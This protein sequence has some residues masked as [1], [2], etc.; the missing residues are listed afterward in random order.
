MTIAELAER[1]KKAEGP[2]REL[3][4]ALAQALV[5]DV[6]VLRRNDD[7]TANEPHTYWEYTGSVDAALGLV[8]RVLPDW[9]PSTQRSRSGFHDCYLHFDDETGW[10]RQSHGQAPTLPLA[11]IAALLSALTESKPATAK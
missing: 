11:I 6:V 1:V 7:D 5:P 3:D 8:E 2:D 4:L 10:L 9:R